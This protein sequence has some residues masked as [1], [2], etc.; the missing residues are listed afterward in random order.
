MEEKTKNIIFIF[1]MA[2]IFLPM[3]QK[4][5]PF[6]K[7]GPLN[8]EYAIAPDTAVTFMSWFDG[9]YW[10]K[11]SKY[12]ND[13]MGFRPDLV[14]LN[15][16]VDFDFFKKIHS[17]WRLIGDNACIFQDV[18]IYSYLGRDFDGYPFILEKVRKLKAIQDTLGKLG[19]SLIFVHAPCKAFYYPEYFPKRYRDTVRCT[20]NFETYKRIGDSLGLNQ[21]DFNTWLVDMKTT[22]KELL[23]PKQGFHWSTYGSLLAADSLIRYI[24]H[25][26]GIRMI[27][28]VWDKIEHTHK[29]RYKDDDISKTMNLIW[30]LANETFSYPE[31]RYEGDKT[32]VKP[33]VIYIGDSFLFQ[34]LDE[35][36]MD[37]TESSWQIWYYYS[38][39]INK[40]HKPDEM[41]P[42]DNYDWVKEMDNSDCIII[43]FTSRNLEKM[44]KN[45]VERTYDHYYPG[46]LK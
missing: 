6:I 17:E 33:R 34:W 5:V 37:N 36:V 42:M 23:Y 4:A 46:K 31:V 21:V 25:L 30:P 39:L 18:Y 3:L 19:K 16:E 10:N 45:F 22:S 40:D 35:G 26:R 13:N 9:S 41:Y 38:S 1:L 43:M 8:G 7:S 12:I 27:H 20:T 24:E 29:A 28:P 11:K 2:I 14:R 15:N 44:G 32:A